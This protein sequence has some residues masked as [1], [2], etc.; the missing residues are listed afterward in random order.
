VGAQ[1]KNKKQVLQT[2]SIT[3]TQKQKENVVQYL[4]E[5]GIKT[6]GRGTKRRIAD[7][8]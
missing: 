3:A 4:E 8:K 2:R 1:N 6:R 7:K 5:E